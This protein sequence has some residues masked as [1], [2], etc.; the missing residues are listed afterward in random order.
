MGNINFIVCRF[1][2][3]TFKLVMIILVTKYYIWKAP[4]RILKLDPR[5]CRSSGDSYDVELKTI[6]ITS[7]KG[8]G[9]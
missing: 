6:H 1:V 4:Q 7:I 9:N 3:N 5:K 8:T 2:Y